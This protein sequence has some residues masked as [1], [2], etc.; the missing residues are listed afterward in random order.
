MREQELEITV[1]KQTPIL[2]ELTRKVL[3]NIIFLFN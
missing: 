1:K 3:V 2:N